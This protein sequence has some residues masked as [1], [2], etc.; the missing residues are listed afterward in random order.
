MHHRTAHVPAPNGDET[1]G[2]EDAQRFT[3]RRA[4]HFEFF[5]K[6]V[7]FGKQLPVGDFAIHDSAPQPGRDE[8]CDARLA[9]LGSSSRSPMRHAAHTVFVRLEGSHI[10]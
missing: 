4:A 6:L 5:E 1:L 8:V 2:L 7:L 10:H 9:Q 3:Q